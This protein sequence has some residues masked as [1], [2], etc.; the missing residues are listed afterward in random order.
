MPTVAMTPHLYRFFPMLQNRQLDVPPG[1]VA[2]VVQAINT[3]AP[4]FCDY[5]L[6]DHGALRKHV[7]ICIN[8]AIV[9]DRKTLS[10]QVQQNDKVFIFQALTGG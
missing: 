8:D 7:N 2:Q 3:I 10:D 4:G 5:V 6:D 9:I 1:S